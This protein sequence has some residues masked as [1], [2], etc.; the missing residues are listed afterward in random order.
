LK[1]CVLLQ[2]WQLS[3]W[4]E[5]LQWSFAL[6]GLHHLQSAG[7]GKALDALSFADVACACCESM[8]TWRQAGES[9]KKFSAPCPEAK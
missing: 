1:H 5:C 6:C 8:G 2:V 9:I 7:A 3:V 4:I